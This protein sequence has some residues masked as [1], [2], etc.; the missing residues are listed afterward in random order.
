MTINKLPKTPQITVF[1]NNGGEITIC[2]HGP[3]ESTDAGAAVSIALDDVDDLVSTLM[4]IRSEMLRERGEFSGKSFT[5][6]PRK[7]QRG[8]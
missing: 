6:I 1:E 2:E 5:T 8:G 3:G 7:A 4:N